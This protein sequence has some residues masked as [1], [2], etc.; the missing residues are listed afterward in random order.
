MEMTAREL[1]RATLGRQLLL[2]REPLGVLDM[3]RRVVALQAQQAASPYVAL[4]NRISDFAPAALDAAYTRREV[5][6]A[7]LM[8]ITLHAVHSDDY[9]VFREAMRPTFHASRLGYRFAAAGLTPAD[10]EELVPELVRFAEQPRTVAEME[11][12]LE[13]RLGTDKKAGAWWGLRAYAP[14]LHAPTG[15]PWSFGHRPSYAAAPTLPAS[16]A[17]DPEGREE[18]LRT[19]VLRYL[20]G[21]G[22]ASVAD[23]AQFAMVQRAPVRA[24]LHALDGTVEQLKGPG[25]TTLFDLPGAPRPPADTP[26]PPRLM[27][28]W[29][30]VLLA[31]ADRSRVIPPEL[32]RLVIRNNGDVLPTLLVD[33][34]VAGVWRQVDGGIEVTAF[35]DLPSDA[36]DG[37][38]AEARCLM[39][40]L[41]ERDPRVYGRYDHWWAKL[42]DGQVR[43]LPG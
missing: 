11:A 24:A 1:N 43:V 27:A 39:T 21:F 9:Q 35:H 41:A 40:L 7:T 25:G 22:P 28:M 19:L 37:L 15:G 10:A 32:R 34:Y 16:A 31:Y 3:V 36:W 38:A 13:Q 8:R 5:V 33:G 12:W 23:V 30:S 20:Q 6:K 42:P 18:A 26:A 4:W 2:R 29:D 17:P 14:L